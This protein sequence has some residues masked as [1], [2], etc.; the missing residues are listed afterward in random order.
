MAPDHHA[1]GQPPGGPPPPPPQPP[2][3]PPSAPPPLAPPP[4]PSVPGCEKDTGGTCPVLS[5]N[6]D[7]GPTNCVDGRCLCQEGYCVSEMLE[8]GTCVVGSWLKVASVLA[9]VCAKPGP[10]LRGPPQ[11]WAASDCPT[12]I[13]P[14][15]D[16]AGSP[17][18]C[19]CS[20]GG[21]APRTRASTSTVI[22][23]V[24]AVDAVGRDFASGA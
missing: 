6:T 13:G 22:T 14:P 24:A 10:A 20:G 9:S 8:Y 16:W 1:P 4:A 18:C 21:A 11:H 17:F 2:S 3:S 5:C 23:S 15:S 19:C 12:P 7:R